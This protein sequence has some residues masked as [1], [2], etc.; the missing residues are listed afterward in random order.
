[1]KITSH[2]LKPAEHKT[3][4]GEPKFHIFLQSIY[5]VAAIYKSY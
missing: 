5:L 2:E 4:Y 3:S 1:M